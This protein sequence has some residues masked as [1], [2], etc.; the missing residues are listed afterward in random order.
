ME[1]LFNMLV[2]I[3]CLSAIGSFVMLFFIGVFLVQ[4]RQFVRE[5]FSDLVDMISGI[6][7]VAPVFVK[8]DSRPKTWDEKFE[9]ELSE[10][11][12]RMKE[13]LGVGLLDLAPPRQNYNAVPAPNPQAQKGLTIHSREDNMP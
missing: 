11:E 4:F 7:P 5:F 9:E 6:E 8:D 3:G 1:I 12:R 2:V 13:E 10:R